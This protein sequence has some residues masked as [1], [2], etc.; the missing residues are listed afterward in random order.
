MSGAP[1]TRHCEQY[2]LSLPTSKSPPKT[3]GEH[4]QTALLHPHAEEHLQTQRLLIKVNVTQQK[5]KKG[6]KKTIQ[7]FCF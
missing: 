2:V 3:Q 5:T 1:A 6:G 7:P 4:P